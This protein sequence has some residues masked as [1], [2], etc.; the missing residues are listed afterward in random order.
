MIRVPTL[1]LITKR[2]GIYVPLKIGCAAG[3]RRYYV[4]ARKILPYPICYAAGIIATKPEKAYSMALQCM[5]QG[6]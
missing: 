6:K 1:N 2:E 5:R 3:R 4:I